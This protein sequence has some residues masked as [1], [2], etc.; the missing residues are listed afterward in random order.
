MARIA[1]MT[2]GA[3]SLTLLQV[4][5][6]QAQPGAEPKV[7]ASTPVGAIPA[8]DRDKLLG[9]SWHG[10]KDRAWTTAG[11]AE[12]LHVMVADAAD[13]YAWRTVATLREAGFDTDRWIGNACVT[14]SGRR[15]VVVYAPRTFTNKAELSGRGGFT[16]VVDLQNGAV[17]KLPV[18][19]SL[20][21]FNPGCGE[22]ES[23]ALTQEG[24]EGL[25]GTQLLR[26]D[27]E[28]GTLGSKVKVNGQ[29]TS[30]VTTRD[31]FVGALSDRLAE[32]GTGGRVTMLAKSRG[33]PFKIRPDNGGGLT[34]LETDGTAMRARRH[35]GGK[36]TTLAE[37]SIGTFGLQRG[38]AGR[39]FLTGAPKAI[40]TLPEGISRLS[41]PVT[42]EVSTSGGLAFERT[43][44]AAET[45]PGATASAG[46]PPAL[47]LGARIV[48]T[49]REFTFQVTPRATPPAS[50]SPMLG[51]PRPSAKARSAEP[52]A[53]ADDVLEPYTP[54]DPDPWCSVPRNDIATLAY[55]PRPR[56]IE[57]AVDYG[58]FGA[59]TQTR[60]ANY[61]GFGLPAYSPQGMFPPR[62]LAG[63]GHVAAQIMLGILAQESNLW[64]A[65]QTE[66]GE[67]GNP[68]IGNYYGRKYYDSDTSDDWRIH[69]NE[70]DCGYGVSQVTDGMRKAGKEKPG[71]TARPATHQRAI[72]L[73]Y[74]A[75]IS[76]GLQ[77]LQDKWN[78]TYSAGLRINNADPARIENWFFAA[79]AYNSGF[80]P[81]KGDDSPWGVGWGNNPI[82]PRYDP[83]RHP[84]LDVRDPFDPD[85]NVPVF[86]DAAHPQDWPY[87]EKVIGWAAQ[88]IDTGDDGVGFRTAYWNGEP[89]EARVRRSQAKPNIWMFCDSTND[90]D[91]LQRVQPNEPGLEGEKP[92]PCLHKNSAGQYDLKCWYHE[93]VTW[94]GDCEESCGYE[95]IR[96]DVPDNYSEPADGTHN[97]P[98]CTASQLPS[99]A[100][101]VDY[102]RSGTS[103]PRCSGVG[104]RND[105]SFKFEFG[106]GW[107]NEYTSKIDFHQVDTGFGGHHWFT[108]ARGSYK[109]QVIG[110]WRPPTS[111]SGWT[112]IYA[113]IPK[114][115]A[116]VNDAVY[117]VATG[118]GRVRQVRVDQDYHKGS[119]VWLGNFNLR[120][121]ASVKLDSVKPAPTEKT[122]GFDAV[123]FVPGGGS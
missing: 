4:P 56:Q 86:S 121:G 122:L 60:P 107:P 72:A 35:K 46:V 98:Q 1:L 40:K 110:T 39:V 75:N 12:G 37:G 20:A 101:V 80:Y 116:R 18:T 43:M 61:R 95:G 24:D 27:A 3:V 89:I 96:Y 108:R 42:A 9:R 104:P 16:A 81:D 6:A 23:A 97:P 120:S 99:N 5:M 62:A 92:G 32:V 44:T 57:W 118:D 78:Q 90:C 114:T 7:A 87:Q 73:D 82:N 15:V 115:G 26:V 106:T 105:G 76:A 66:S 71:E 54:E 55:H 50:D 83:T 41:V 33:V 11:D 111:Y 64:Q 30:A 65:S 10:S 69:W 2:T 25:R 74:A 34:F 21:Y 113:Y 84:F 88:S 53:A 77:I 8:A 29:L 102:V 68:L 52:N 123:A 109:F 22:G 31:G 48:E 93:P 63:G 17:T 112:G 45:L 38:A 85:D 51:V 91:Q 94:K 49:G 47:E 36:V 59:L 117:D 79:W 19:G 103:M 13:G 100:I 70:A 58:I 119:W 14:S 67:Y 28:R